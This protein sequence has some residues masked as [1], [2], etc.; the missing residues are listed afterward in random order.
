MTAP[1]VTSWLLHPDI[2]LARGGIGGDHAL[3]QTR[4]AAEILRRLEKQ[5]GVILADEVGMGKT[6]VALAV[7]ASV[8]LTSANP[9][10]VMVPPGLLDKWERDGWRF[11]R[12]CLEDGAGR[13]VARFRIRRAETGAEFLRCFD[14]PPERRTHIVLLAN[15]A[16]HRA[17]RDPFLRLDTLRR[18]LNRTGAADAVRRAVARFAHDLLRDSRLHALSEEDILHLMGIPPDAWLAFLRAQSYKIEDDP[19][20]RAFRQALRDKDL[21]RVAEAVEWVPLRD[22]VNYSE[23]IAKARG[24]LDGVFRDV[25]SDVLHRTKVRSPLLVLDEAHHL[26]NGETRLAGLFD[27]EA[28]DESVVRDAFDRMLFLTATPFQ[29]GHHELLGVLQRFRAVRW[30]SL[31][32]EDA[33]AQY[34][35]TLQ[36]LGKALDRAQLEGLR[37]DRAWGQ[38]TAQ[39]LGL[40]PGASLSDEAWARLLATPPATGVVAEALAQYRKV[41]GA[42]REAEQRLRPWVIRHLRE[43]QMDGDAGPVARRSTLTGRAIAGGAPHLGLEVT[44]EARFPF[45]LCGRAQGILARSSGN[46]GYFAEGLASSYGAFLDTSRGGRPVDDPDTS[47]EAGAESE[48]RWYVDA[49]ERFVRDAQGRMNHP[50]VEATVARAIRHWMD[51]EK[52]L[53]F[54][55]FRQTILDLRDRLR[56]AVERELEQTATLRLGLGSADGAEAMD[57][58]RRIGDRLRAPES[59]MHGAVVRVLARWVEPN[60]SLTRGQRDRVVKLL[61][62]ELATRSFVIRSLPIDRP[63]VRAALEADRMTR[64]QARTAAEAVG[65]SLA[66]RAGVRG[67]RQRVEAFLAHVATH[68]ATEEERDELLRNLEDS[69]RDVVRHADGGVPRETRR[70]VLL[71]FNSPLLPEILVA[72]E[73]M[74]EGIDLHLECRHVIHHDLSWNPS[75]LEQRT[76]RVDR[77][78][79]RA[80]IDK[81]SILVYLPYL[82]GTADEKMYRVVSDRAR[83]FQVVMGEKYPVDEASTERLAS[84]VP[85]P[86]SAADALTLDLS[87]G[88]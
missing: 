82:E 65:E 10:V 60:A 23:R 31:K 70:R 55:H 78:R 66:R 11:R 74:A 83:W 52:V 68:L 59:P 54:A 19:V 39:D 85:L 24:A 67:Y 72:S 30:E 13:G 38:L 34:D 29:L 43:R 35:V 41:E 32:P 20:P 80:E 63:E 57:R 18:A 87:V 25:W 46:R 2:A 79:C 49:V 40:D 26:K 15:T 81:Q 64:E 4:T 8:A 3:R 36:R 51:G 77:L 53:L 7:A 22:S 73:V 76:G 50:K 12:L 33:L 44:G 21:D 88:L 28:P 27:R 17:E 84:R 62:G 61:L 45:L 16:F 42:L 5:P 37:L 69:E 48:L 86:Q 6:F 75:T 14:D 71:G 47:V 58:V 56:A 1:G 9:V